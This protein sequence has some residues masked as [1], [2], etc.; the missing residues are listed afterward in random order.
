MAKLDIL[1]PQWKED[2]KVIKPL[3]DSIAMQRSVDLKNDIQVIIV[4]DGTDVILS[5]EFLNSYEFNIKYLKNEKNMDISYTRNKAFDSGDSEY[6]MF[7]DDDDMFFSA[8]GLYTIFEYINEVDEKTGMLGFDVLVPTFKEELTNNWGK[9]IYYNRKKDRTFNHGKVYRR[10]YLED[11]NIRFSEKISRHEDVYFNGIALAATPY[12]K[13]VDNCYYLWCNNEKSVTRSSKNFVLDS[14][15]TLVTCYYE[16]VREYLE[17]GLIKYARV[18][19]ANAL[20]RMYYEA[21]TDKFINNPDRLYAMEKETQKFYFKY[22]NLYNK[23][24]LDEKVDLLKKIKVSFLDEIL[25]E[26]IPFDEW[27]NH[28]K[29]LK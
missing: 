8:L 29:E 6:V 23:V 12:V 28:I 26:K 9:T 3:L 24:S 22:E 21:Q 10:A 4:N 16:L 7:C 20:Y 15:E 19:T 13:E 18:N 25:F 14:I 17:R 27:L 2:E 11:N 5:D 1:I